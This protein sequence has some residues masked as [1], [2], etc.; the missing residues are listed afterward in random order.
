M[1]ISW[2]IKFWTHCPTNVSM[3]RTEKKWVYFT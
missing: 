3:C 1:N 2:T